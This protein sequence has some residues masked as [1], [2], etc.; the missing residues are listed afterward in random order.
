MGGPTQFLSSCRQAVQQVLTRH[1]PRRILQALFKMPKF[2]QQRLVATLGHSLVVSFT[3]VHKRLRISTWCEVE[4]TIWV[5]TYHGGG[6][7]KAPYRWNLCGDHYDRVQSRWWGGEKVAVFGDR[8]CGRRPKPDFYDRP[9]GEAG[10]LV[11]TWCTLCLNT[12]FLPR[13]RICSKKSTRNQQNVWP[14]KNIHTVFY[15][16]KYFCFS[17]QDSRSSSHGQAGRISLGRIL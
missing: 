14:I 7:Q 4:E 8:L 11:K 1:L 3:L 17:H 13:L 2:R 10:L 5:G 9:S 12:L 16:M 15:N 6:W